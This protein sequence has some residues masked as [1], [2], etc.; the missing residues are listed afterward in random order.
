MVQL[1]NY[2]S[3]INTIVIKTMVP[4]IWK[5]GHS[6]SGCFCPDLSG[7]WQNG[8][9]FSGFQMIGLPDFRS[10]SKIK[11]ICKPIPITNISKSRWVWISDPQWNLFSKACVLIWLFFDWP[12]SLWPGVRSSSG[13]HQS[14]LPTGL[15]PGQER[16]KRDW[17]GLKLSKMRARVSKISTRWLYSSV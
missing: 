1:H 17:V 8:S 12:R 5:L 10:Q 14:R 7:F 4:A 2:C 3:K 15:S 11:T 6:K 13:L 16:S 9:R